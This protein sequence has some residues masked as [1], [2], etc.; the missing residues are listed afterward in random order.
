MNPTVNKALQAIAV[1]VLGLI[2]PGIPSWLWAAIVAALF[3]GEIT[4]AHIMEFAALHNIKAVPDYDI[5]KN[6][7]KSVKLYSVGEE[8]GNFNKRTS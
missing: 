6:G 5:E 4:P 1:Y 2:C 3:S 7:T 8:N